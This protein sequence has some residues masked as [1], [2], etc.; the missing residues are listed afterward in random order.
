MISLTEQDEHFPQMWLENENQLANKVRQS[1]TEWSFST[2]ME[3]ERYHCPQCD[4]VTGNHS[5][6]ERHYRIH[7]G[8]KPFSCSLCSY[9]A[10]DKSNLLK[11]L[12]VHTN[13]KRFS[14]PHCTYKSNRN[15]RVLYHVQRHHKEA[16]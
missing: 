7:T 15:D 8:E 4:Y 9:Q 16:L 13:E 12:Q 2:R 3:Q 10:R 14:C 1:S 5:N 11:H 6:Y